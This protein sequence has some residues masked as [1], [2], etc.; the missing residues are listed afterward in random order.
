MRWL[1]LTEPR[2]RNPRI[3]LLNVD[4]PIAVNHRFRSGS[5][6][7]LVALVGD[8]HLSTDTDAV[9]L[10]EG[11]G[12][13]FVDEPGFSFRARSSSARALLIEAGQ[14]AHEQSHESLTTGFRDQGERP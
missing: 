2:L 5:I 1:E 7:Y 4:A 8:A 12:A 10:E 9:D 3:Y 14:T 13:I 11:G 6:G